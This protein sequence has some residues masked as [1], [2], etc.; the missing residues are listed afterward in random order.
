MPEALPDHICPKCFS[1][2]IE[3]VPRQ[4]T[5]DHMKGLFGWRVYHCRDC[6]ARFHDRPV[7]RT[8]S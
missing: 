2:D 8:T 6:G 5:A 7:E 1:D 3:R 4:H